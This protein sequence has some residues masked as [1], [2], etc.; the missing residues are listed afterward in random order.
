MRSATIKDVAERAGVSLKTVSRVINN[1]PS[2]H[3]RTRERVQQAIDALG[4][5]PD[6]SARSLRSTRAYAI[7]LVYDNPNAH[8][9][10]NLQRG[11]LSVCRSSGFGLQIHPCD[12]FL[13]Q[14]GRRAVLA[15][16]PRPPGRVG[17][18]AADVGATRA[19]PGPG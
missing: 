16:A 14:A 9:I 13:A 2:V 5:Q 10:I 11:V 17:A 18:G 15:G 3:A 4:Y 12:S 8:Y 19:D 1:E 6:P 7:G